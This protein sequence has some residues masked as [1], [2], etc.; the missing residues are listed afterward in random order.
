MTTSRLSDLSQGLKGSQILRIAAEVRGLMAQGRPVCNL[1]VGDFSPKEFP[2]PAA[3][4]E[5][6]ARLDVVP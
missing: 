3:L 2:V 4:A 6:I 1:T 5:S